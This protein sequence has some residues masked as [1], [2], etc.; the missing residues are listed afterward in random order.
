MSVTIGQAIQRVQSRYSKGV[1]SDDTRLSSRHIY[2]KL[3]DVRNTIITQ[4]ANKNQLIAPHVYQSLPCLE[5]IDAP[6]SECDNIPNI[7]YI[8]RSRFPLPN[9]LSSND[10]L[11][12]KSITTLDGKINYTRADWYTIKYIKANKYTGDVP[13][14]IIKSNGD[15]NF[16]YLSTKVKPEAIEVIAIYEDPIEVQIF[17]NY[18][19]DY[20]N[21]NC[22]NYP[23]LEFPVELDMLNTIVE[24][25]VKEMMESFTETQQDKNNNSRD[26]NQP[27]VRQDQI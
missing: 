16:L 13:R 3:L 17:P 5:M 12:I 20:A 25:I 2:S 1:Q 22:L 8:L 6:I 24:I 9:I 26:E 14:Y 27:T 19:N 11:L 21:P 18:C 7:G 10:K 15:N 23:D 4:T